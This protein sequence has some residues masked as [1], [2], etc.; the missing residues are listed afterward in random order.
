MSLCV[1][2]MLLVDPKVM[3]PNISFLTVVHKQRDVIPLDMNDDAGESDEDD[4]QP[5]FDVEV[6]ISYL[7]NSQQ[8]IHSN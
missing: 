2:V 6:L 7:F 1:C 8:L 4:E 3:N 5:V